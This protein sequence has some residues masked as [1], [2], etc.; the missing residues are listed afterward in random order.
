MTYRA[1]I[2]VQTTFIGY[3]DDATEGDW[4]HGVHVHLDGARRVAVA[5]EHTERDDTIEIREIGA[6]DD[7]T[8]PDAPDILAAAIAAL[9]ARGIT[10]PAIPRAEA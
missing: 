8:G 4:L 1:S 6:R 5:F 9:D 10:N 3:K 2:I 7:Y